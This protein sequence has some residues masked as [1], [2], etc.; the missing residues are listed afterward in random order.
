MDDD[1][2]YITPKDFEVLYGV[3][4]PLS[5]IIR[6]GGGHLLLYDLETLYYFILDEWNMS[7]DEVNDM[8]YKVKSGA[9]RDYQYEIG[10]VS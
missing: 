4:T 6:T 10:W 2:V 7:E 5:A 9:F 3:F 1:V 8:F